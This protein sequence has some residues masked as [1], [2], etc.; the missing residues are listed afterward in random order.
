MSHSPY[1]GGSGVLGSGGRSPR[2]RSSIFSER[3]HDDVVPEP[4]DGQDDVPPPAAA[5]WFGYGEP[6]E[7][8]VVAS[9]EAAPT[10]ERVLRGL[11]L[12]LVAIVG[13]VV[14]AVLIWRAGF[15]AGISSLVI[16]AGAVTLY[17]IGAGTTPRRGAVP[18]AVLVVVG[19]VASFFAV[20]A[21]DLWDAYSQLAAGE[22]GDV[23]LLAL[24]SRSTFI[25]ENLTN[26]DVLAEYRADG[27]WFA[28]FAALGVF[29]TL[30]RMLTQ[31]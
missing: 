20:V 21:S 2:A 7:A 27:A 23:S 4:T 30:R 18:L 1:T 3:N 10:E 11:A 15:I 28:L 16:A 14:L 13:G 6:V 9:V 5:P 8:G 22:L 29:G 12:S 31:R 26:G 17:A 25:R 19:V 24:P